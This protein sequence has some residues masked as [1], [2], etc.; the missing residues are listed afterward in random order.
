[1]TAKEL[2]IGNYVYLM[3]NHQDYETLSVTTK[4]LEYIGKKQGDYQ[5]IPL[6][7]EWL[8]KFGYT[9]TGFMGFEKGF[10]NNSILHI[11]FMAG[12]VITGFIEGDST[13]NLIGKIDFVHQLQ[14]LFF[15]LRGEE[16]TITKE[17]E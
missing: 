5:P 16:L 7:K 3:L 14:N 9:E 15:A 2:R 13:Y 11:Q 12:G 1:M 6:T 17:I 8:V 10:S 4:D